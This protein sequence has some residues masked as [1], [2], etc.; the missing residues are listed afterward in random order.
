MNAVNAINNSQNIHS[1]SF[2]NIPDP[3]SEKGN[4]DEIKLC[5]L[6]AEHN[7]VF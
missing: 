3:L 1:L 5:T 6:L 4:T 7:C 2:S